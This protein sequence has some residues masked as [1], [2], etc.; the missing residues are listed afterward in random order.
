[1]IHCPHRHDQGE[2]YCPACQRDKERQRVL[3]LINQRL[4]ESHSRDVRMAFLRL[5]DEL[6]S[7]RQP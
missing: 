4:T 2:P 6:T 7:A 5:K 1:M 3:D